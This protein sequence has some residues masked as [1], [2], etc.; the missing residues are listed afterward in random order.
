MPIMLKKITA[1]AL[2]ATACAT[3]D[4]LI[5]PH[6]DGSLVKGVAHAQEDGDD[7]DDGDDGGDDD[8][9]DDGGFG[10]G[11]SPG[12]GRGSGPV[13]DILRGPVEGLRGLFQRALPRQPT[14]RR[15]AE[16]APEPLPQR[17]EREL[18]ALD[19]EAEDIATLEAD[20][21]TIAERVE[22]AM[23]DAELIRLVVPDGLSLEDAR[24]A[25]A[26]LADEAVVDFNHYYRTEA[27]PTEGCEGVQCPSREMVDWHFAG[28]GAQACVQPALIGLI[29]TGINPDHES[30]VEGSLTIVAR[31]GEAD[32][33]SDI[34][35][36]TAIAAL[37]V[38]S[39][40][41]RVPG[42]LPGAELL[43]V[44]AFLQAGRD[45]R[46]TVFDLVRAADILAGEEVAVLN[47]SLAGPPN[48]LLEKAIAALADEDVVVVAA[49]G[50]AG[51]SAEAAYP[52]AYDDVIAVTAV[53]R[54][55]RPYRRAG[56]GAHIDVA[57]PGVDIWTAASISGHRP[58]TGTSFAAPFVTAAAALAKAVDPAITAA[59]MEELLAET[60]GEMGEPGRDPV[61]GWGLLD[62]EHLCEEALAR[63]GVAVRDIVPVVFGPEDVM[64]R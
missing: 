9:D 16:P 51:P 23:V 44:D 55:G 54:S 12:I 63:T 4:A 47:L 60:A 21:Y 33:L 46:A 56:R 6:L 52:A 8:G 25:V 20:G 64:P 45:T 11:G 39:S 5:V 18:A 43:A 19:L 27:R 10:G 7:G 41:A 53:D 40:D 42:L 30:F 15:V 28:P 34:K 57:A 36:G 1:L 50:N 58:E 13:P 29:D 62:M 24:D 17:A 37:M 14:P 38:G 3:A 49:A 31:F 48:A 61:F 35:H 2:V 22:I 32:S 59:G 26:A